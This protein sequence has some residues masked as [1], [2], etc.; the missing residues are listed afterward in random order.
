MD[1]RS[2]C[3][4][5]TQKNGDLAPHAAPL[6]R[7][8][9]AH[10]VIIGGGITGAL[11]AHYLT[12]AG[13]DTVMVDRRSPAAGSTAAST[14]LLQYEIDKP[15]VEL[16]ALVGP[17]HAAR[18]YRLGV[19]ALDEFERLTR[20]LGDDCGFARRRSVFLATTPEMAEL[21]AVECRARAA[22]GLRVEY[23]SRARLEGAFGFDRPGAILSEDAAEVDPVR[24][25]AALV[26]CAAG[27]G[28][29]VFA[30]TPVEDYRSDGRAVT[31]STAAGYRVRADHVIFATGYETPT[32]LTDVAVELK[33]TYALAARV[34][35]RRNLEPAIH[36]LP[37][38]WETGTPYF[39]ARSDGPDRLIAGGEDDD[40]ADPAARDAR[41]G[42]KA[43]RVAG[44][45][46]RLLPHVSF[47]V[48]CAWAGTFAET[49][50]GLPYIG[51]H[52]QCPGGLF[53]LGYGGNGITFGLIAARLLRDQSLGRPNADAE[54]FRFDRPS[55]R[56]GRSE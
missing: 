28:L 37:L 33:S 4:Y 14:G 48:D 40:F 27:R 2:G 35:R 20:E 12:E 23:L 6:D 42:E 15:L 26:R 13:V 7:D 32:F 47:E 41:I 50:D 44:K 1:L 53:A 18:A 11:A 30:H 49:P 51:P 19:D 29:R 45:V 39:Y 5:W 56:G 8:L 36:D 10:V 17:A 54:V 21:L 9:S 22:V 31:L 34:E 43:E 24:M 3:E 38:L 25:T 52:R 55:V 16:S 46:A